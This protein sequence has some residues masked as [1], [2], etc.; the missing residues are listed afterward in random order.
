MADPS[1][2]RLIASLTRALPARASHRT[3]FSFRLAVAVAALVCLSALGLGAQQAPPPPPAQPP[4]TPQVTRVQTQK[5]QHTPYVFRTNVGEVLVHA[6]VLDNKNR[7]VLDLKQSDFTV[8]EN[9]VQ[10]NVDYF[11]HDDAPIA[12]GLLIDNS[13]SMRSKRPQVDKAALNFVRAS[14]PDDQVFVV[15]FNDEYYLDADFTNS[16]PKL[17]DGLDHIDS[18]GG[19]ALYDA[20]IA[21][22]DHLH[23]D[24]KRQKKVLLIITDG[25]DDASRYTLEQTV[26]MAQAEKGPL[27]Y[28]VGLIGDM[29]GS[30]KRHAERALKALASATG[31]EA[32]F[33]KNL[34]QVNAIT[35][36]MAQIIRQQYTLAYRSNQNTPGFRRIDVEAHA[37]HQKNLKVLARTG[38][39]QGASGVVSSVN[40]PR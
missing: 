3:G 40:Q 18:R 10:Q 29:G 24:A 4:S 36:N 39:Y 11:S 6:T 1:P 13:G 28:C 12:V 2:H 37:P 34:D 5:G 25:E 23:Q 20:T 19:T 7:P 38:Y 35:R 30:E 33:A 31:G 27:I 9:G 16:I 26:R 14:N 22:L 15:N 21:S 32:F 8:K 17:E